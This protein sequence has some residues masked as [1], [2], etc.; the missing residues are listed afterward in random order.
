MDDIFKCP[1]TP[2]AEENWFSISVQGVCTRTPNLGPNIVAF[3]E[4]VF[5]SYLSLSTSY[6]TQPVEFLFSC[7]VLPSDISFYAHEVLWLT[8]Y[9]WSSFCSPL[10]GGDTVFS[11]RCCSRCGGHTRTH[12]LPSCSYSFHVEKEHH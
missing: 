9:A 6:L 4:T 2:D 7:H 10:K 1:S 5:G 11:Q 3:L 12:T 8:F